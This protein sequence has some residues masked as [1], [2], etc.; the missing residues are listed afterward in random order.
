MPV[1]WHACTAVFK[2]IAHLISIMHEQEVHEDTV[3]GDAEAGGFTF[4]QHSPRV[5]ANDNSSP[6]PF[7]VPAATLLRQGSS[8]GHVL[9]MQLAKQPSQAWAVLSVDIDSQHPKQ[10]DSH[11]PGVLASPVR[12]WLNR[13]EPAWQLH[14][15]EDKAQY[16][17]Q[18]GVQD[19]AEGPQTQVA[20][21]ATSRLRVRVAASPEYA[22]A[23]DREKP[24]VFPEQGEVSWMG[25]LDSA[26]QVSPSAVIS[27]GITSN[28]TNQTQGQ[29]GQQ[30]GAGSSE[31]AAAD[32]ETFD[33]IPLTPHAENDIETAISTTAE[34]RAD[35]GMGDAEVS[36][37][38]GDTVDGHIQAEG[39]MAL[40]DN[41][42][43]EGLHARDE[44]SEPAEWFGN[45]QPGTADISSN[46]LDASSDTSSLLTDIRKAQRPYSASRLRESLPS[47]KVL[48]EA[49][50]T[51]V[52]RI[53][54]LPKSLGRLMRNSGSAGGDVGS[55]K[56]RCI[57]S[58]A[59]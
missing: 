4:A 15:D 43:L 35:I 22:A 48:K 14:E 52:G 9:G 36:S 40:A 7:I 30:H 47:L 27:F 32:L 3:E 2:T 23:I 39:S 51:G 57:L 45:S 46:V 42:Q 10:P 41:P 6:I 33:S 56:N 38:L 13:S 29:I 49:G 16:S 12:D 31:T 5:S 21:N 44:F 28:S 1:K 54:S 19:T 20:S 50:S 24:D 8:T 26:E 55:G 58:V 53:T 34:I 17:V 59:L 18:G 11:E 37:S 25:T